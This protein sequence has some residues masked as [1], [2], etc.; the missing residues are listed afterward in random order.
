MEKPKCPSTGMDKEDAVHLYNG[1]LFSHTKQWNHAIC[2]NV[3]GPRDYHMKWSQR[4]TNIIW[5]HLYVESKK[6]IQMNSFTNQKLTRRHWKQ[7]HGYQRQK[8]EGRDKL[9]FGIDIYTLL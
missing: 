1:I 9:E 7:A 6:I 4:K 5:Y 8:G 2:S 3:D